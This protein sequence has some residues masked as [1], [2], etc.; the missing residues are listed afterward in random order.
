M[1][2]PNFRNF[3]KNVLQVYGHDPNKNVDKIFDISQEM[4]LHNFFSGDN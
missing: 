3:S 2:R 4:F 1:F